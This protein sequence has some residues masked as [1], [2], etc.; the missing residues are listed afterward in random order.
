MIHIG[1]DPGFQGGIAVISDYRTF[2]T[3]MPTY[4]IEVK[5]KRGLTK[6]KRYDLLKLRRFLAPY[7][8][9]HT[10]KKHYREA[11]ECHVTLEEAF[12]MPAQGVTSMYS[13][14]LGYGI[15]QGLLTG[16]DM[17]YTTVHPKTWQAEFQIRTNEEKTTKEQALAICEELFPDVNLLSSERA[18]M[19]H[20]G[21]VDALLIA[22]YGKRKYGGDK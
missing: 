15:F 9:M 13:V 11:T 6:R 2:G 5:T 20:K 7:A 4:N 16:F 14:G 19:P 18:T 22:E 3:P 17:E 21:I 1:I 10:L 12:P 8:T